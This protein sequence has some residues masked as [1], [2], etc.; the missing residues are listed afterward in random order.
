MGELLMC[1]LGAK[2]MLGTIYSYNAEPGQT[3]SSYCT[4]ASGMNICPPSKKVV[5]NN[6]LKFGTRVG[7]DG[8]VYE[9]QD[10]MARRYGC[11]VFDILLPTRAESIRWGKRK[12]QLIIYDDRL[13]YSAK[14]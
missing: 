8:I 9:V 6:C 2:I 1:A 5:A 10:R 13:L 4:T 14:R 7:I 11:E 3:D 12:K